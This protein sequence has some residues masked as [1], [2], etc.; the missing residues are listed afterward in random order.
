MSLLVANSPTRKQKL[1]LQKSAQ[2]KLIWWH[3]RKVEPRNI[4]FFCSFG[5]LKSI[6]TLSCSSLLSAH[7]S[8]KGLKKVQSL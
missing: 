5:L 6:W 2:Y 8:K 3:K 1:K 7:W 4:L